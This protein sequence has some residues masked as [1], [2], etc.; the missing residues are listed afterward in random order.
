MFQSSDSFIT[1]AI[2]HQFSIK[3]CSPISPSFFFFCSFFYSFFFI[4]PCLLHPVHIFN[5][6]NFT[7]GTLFPVVRNWRWRMVDSWEVRIQGI[8]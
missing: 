7:F 1:L 5:S 2:A 3:M 6:I 8:Q 4:L